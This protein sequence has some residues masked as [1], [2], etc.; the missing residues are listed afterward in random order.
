MV[1]SNSFGHEF[2]LNWDDEWYV[3]RNEWIRGLTPEH[4]KNAFTRVYLWNYA[5]MHLISYMIDYEIMQLSPV[6]YHVTNVGI[7]ILNGFLVYRILH[8]LHGSVFAALA[9]GLFFLVH[10]V[11]VESVAW[12][13]ER[14][15]VLSILFFLAS[16][17]A[18][19]SHRHTAG[20]RAYIFSLAL[21][22]MAILTKS[23]AVVLP[24]V[25]VLHD[26]FFPTRPDDR[27]TASL[28][29]TMPYFVLALGFGL[30][31]VSHQS[32]TDGIYFGN[33]RLGAFL[34]L[35]VIFFKYIQLILHPVNLSAFYHVPVVKEVWS[36]GW[37]ASVAAVFAV[38]GFLIRWGASCRKNPAG[39]WT[40]LALISLAPVLQ[41]IPMTT[42][43]NDRYLYLP[44]LG[45]SGLFAMLV[46]RLSRDGSTIRKT[47]ARIG[48]LALVAVLGNLSLSQ[49]A[50]W[51]NSLTL[52][53]HAA[54][55]SPESPLAHQKYGEAMFAYGNYAKAAAQFSRAIDLGRDDAYVRIRRG[56]AY[57]RIG[58]YDL[59]I[60]DF[61]KVSEKERY[62]KQALLELAAT[63]EMKK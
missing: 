36:V 51:E 10:P 35:P 38:L 49:T 41:I 59:A 16:L 7:H 12:I 13:S 53:S 28:R 54:Q 1:Y 24:P 48:I 8:A 50:V 62:R 61:R 34:T 9:G 60:L 46:S 44:M 29:K 21:F 52:W 2:L 37:I 25:L 43:M 33:D 4:I 30:A 40:A 20:R 11:Q 19:I 47:A 6:I 23:I 31:A 42:P 22:V 39:F 57:R 3:V 63:E 17:L 26:Y 56:V 45:I 14:K 55:K 5:P 27:L 58:Q 32:V 18:Y 15:N